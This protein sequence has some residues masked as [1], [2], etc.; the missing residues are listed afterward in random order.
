M[1]VT[2]PTPALTVMMMMM[3]PGLAIVVALWMMFRCG[4]ISVN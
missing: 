4:S 1:V 3:R 2:P